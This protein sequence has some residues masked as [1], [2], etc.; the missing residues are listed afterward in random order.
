MAS[1]K[2]KNLKIGYPSKVQ[3]HPS[4]SDVED[5]LNY[6][7]KITSFLSK[8]NSLFF[9]R[10]EECQISFD[11]VIGDV[12]LDCDLDKLIN[13]KNGQSKDH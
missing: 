7:L 11:E 13:L 2:L 10:L 8:Q 3:T 6:E 5:W 12:G 9:V 1:I 4:D